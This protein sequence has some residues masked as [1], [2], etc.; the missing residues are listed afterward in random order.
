[1]S[2]TFRDKHY[3]THLK[4]L[5]KQGK[6][7]HDH[8]C[9]GTGLFITPIKKYSYSDKYST[10]FY[11]EDYNKA[12]EYMQQI[13]TKQ[14]EAQVTIEERKVVKDNYDDTIY[15]ND[16]NN[17]KLIDNYNDNILNINDC[18]GSTYYDYSKKKIIVIIVEFPKPNLYYTKYCTDW[19][20]Y[21]PET[22][23]DIRD[24]G[25]V[26]CKPNVYK[27]DYG[28][29]YYCDC[30]YCSSTKLNKRIQQEKKFLNLNDYKD[31]YN[32]GLTIEELYNI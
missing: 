7:E 12:L 10:F 24:N 2:K 3:K 18:P 15:F 32:S 25:I 11:K 1:M 5:W 8:R 20:H 22:N 26:T 19:D 13:K 4:E 21:D 23:T 9:L 30:E 6:I 29:K 17:F 27:T 28:Y 16:Y 14:P 31:Y